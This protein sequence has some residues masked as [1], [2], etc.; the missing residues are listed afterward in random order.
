MGLGIVFNHCPWPI[1][2]FFCPYHKKQFQ[3]GVVETIQSQHAYHIVKDLFLIKNFKWKIPKYM[4]LTKF[5]MVQVIGLV[6]NEWCFFYAHL[7]EY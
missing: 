1:N 4:K 6:E 5:N 2:Y 3:I 7:N